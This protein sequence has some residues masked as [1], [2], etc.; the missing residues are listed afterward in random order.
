MLLESKENTAGADYVDAGMIKEAGLLSQ[1]VHCSTVVEE[2]NE[3][4]LPE[5]AP[6]KLTQKTTE[7]FEGTEG[8]TNS[9]TITQEDDSE[10]KHRSLILSEPSMGKAS[11]RDIQN[12]TCTSDN[13]EFRD[14][15]KF[16]NTCNYVTTYLLIIELT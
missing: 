1:D 7:D 10:I 14:E 3:D 13:M 4:K 15:V 9:T 5:A 6:S 16:Q 11:E 2:A 12:K 8:D